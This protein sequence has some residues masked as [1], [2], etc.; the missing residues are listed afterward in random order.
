MTELLTKLKRRK[1]SKQQ[2]SFAERYKQCNRCDLKLNI[3]NDEEIVCAICGETFCKTCIN[4]HQ[5][6]CFQYK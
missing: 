3:Y 6:F 1:F 2:K 5:R 4:K